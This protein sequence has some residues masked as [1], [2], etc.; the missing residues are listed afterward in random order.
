MFTMLSTVYLFVFMLD[1]T[2]NFIA[3][4]NSIRT[5]AMFLIVF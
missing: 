4:N 5:V 3:N 2:L 1:E